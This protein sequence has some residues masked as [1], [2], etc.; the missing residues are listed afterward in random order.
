LV[1]FTD[2]KDAVVKGNLNGNI[3]FEKQVRLAPHE[4][5]QVTFVPGFPQLNIRN[6][7]IWWP[8]QPGNRIEQN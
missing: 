2:K 7:R 5:R 6:P 3:H 4:R 8:W 1:N